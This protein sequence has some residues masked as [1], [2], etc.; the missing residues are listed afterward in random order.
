MPYTTNP[1]LPRVRGEAIKLV[2]QGWGIRQ[3][4]RHLGFH[5]STVL[6][7]TRRGMDVRMNNIPTKSSRPHRHPRALPQNIVDRIVALRL[8]HKRCSE[9]IHHFLIQEGTIVSLNSVKRVLKRAGLLKERS[10]WKKY[11]VSP[12]RPFVASA[13]DLVQI[14]TIH[15]HPFTGERFYIYTLLDVHSRWAHAKVSAKITAGRTLKFLEEAKQKAP[16]HFKM[17]QSDH[18][19]EFAKWFTK[20]A[21][22]SHRYSRVRRPNDNAHLERFNRTIQEECLYY[23]KQEPRIYQAAIRKYIP[24]Y[25]NE[26]PHLALGMLSP[27]K[28]CQAI[29]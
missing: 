15:I 4:A 5:P 3:V 10:P 17:L 16:F 22:Q 2:R 11:H 18:G 26:R 7:W 23:L 25:N 12:K 19:P 27:S 20:H 14:D 1:H 21:K 24:F 6:R 29:G 28:C 9:V 13:G 8:Q